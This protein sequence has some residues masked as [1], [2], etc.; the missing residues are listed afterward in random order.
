M[1]KK[2]VRTP[3]ARVGG[4]ENDRTATPNELRKTSAN[5]SI[6]SRRAGDPAYPDH[7]RSN[8]LTMQSAAAQ[9]RGDNKYLD[10]SPKVGTT[11]RN[12]FQSTGHDFSG[13]NC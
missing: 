6:G 9:R 7:K 4:T 8:K 3:S 12:G 1:S 13:S 2:E 11:E 10:N 5:Y